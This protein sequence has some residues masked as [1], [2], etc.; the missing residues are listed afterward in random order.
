MRNIQISGVS[1]EDAYRT[2]RQTILDSAKMKGIKDGF[3]KLPPVKK[4]IPLPSRENFNGRWNYEQES[5]NQNVTIERVA[6]LQYEL[7]KEGYTPEQI[8]VIVGS[9][10]GKTN[11]ELITSLKTKVEYLTAEVK[12]DDAVKM[13]IISEEENKGLTDV[14]IT[15]KVN[16]ER[17]ERLGVMDAMGYNPSKLSKRQA[18][19]VSE[20]RKMEVEKGTTK[21]R[22]EGANMIKGEYSE[23]DLQHMKKATLNIAKEYEK[24][25]K[26]A[27]T[28]K[29]TPQPIQAPKNSSRTAQQPKVEKAEHTIKVTPNNKSSNIGRTA[30]RRKDI[31]NKLKDNI[32]T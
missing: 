31:T 8:D 1:E 30:Q 14:Q 3:V 24:A 15:E 13:N 27:Q 6:E 4:K 17:F 26:V 7:V 2:A 25:A 19:V 32:D 9:C 16:E 18:R 10:E 29:V 12:R 21:Y 5:G 20:I 28:T 22:Q 11:V 23:N